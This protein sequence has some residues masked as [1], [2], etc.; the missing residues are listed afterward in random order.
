[1]GYNNKII[2]TQEEISGRE[3]VELE[4]MG[5]KLRNKHLGG[6]DGDDEF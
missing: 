4:Y 5:G 2:V 6:R 1:M 3:I